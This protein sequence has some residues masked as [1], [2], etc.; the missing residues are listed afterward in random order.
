MKI[1]ILFPLA[2]A[3]AGKGRMIFTKWQ[4]DYGGTRSM[5]DGRPV[6]IVESTVKRLGK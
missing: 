2:L 3:G 1:R 6:L 5:R 4:P